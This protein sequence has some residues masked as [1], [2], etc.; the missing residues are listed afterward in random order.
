M[1]SFVAAS[2]T[3][4]P[5]STVTG[6]PS[7]SSVIAL[8]SAGLSVGIVWASVRRELGEVDAGGAVAARLHDAALVVDVVLEL[9][10]VGLHEGAHGHRRG[11]SEGADGAPLDVVREVEQQ[12]QVLLAALA[13]LDA[14]DDAVEPARALAA[15]RA[16]AARL[17]EVEVGEALGRL[18]HAGVLVH[19]DHGAR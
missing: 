13:R 1:P 3:V 15:G 10:A 12:V 11:V 7:I 16:L 2:I 4:A 19:H 17:L 18:H 5:P 8:G 9:V 14:V 6:L